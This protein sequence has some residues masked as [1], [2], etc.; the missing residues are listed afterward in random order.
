MGVGMS[1]A[2]GFGSPRMDATT[3]LGALIGAA[4]THLWRGVMLRHGL[5]GLPFGRL[6]PRLVAGVVTTAVAAELL[7]WAAGLFVTRAYTMAGSTPGVMFATAANWLFTVLSWTAIYVGAQWF[8]RWRDSEIQ[9]LRLE[10]LARDAQ[11]DALHAQIQ[12]HFLF[13]AM[14]VLRALI[15]EDPAR[16]RDLVTE[17][18]ELMRYALQAGRRER[19]TLAEE[20]SVVESYLRV[21]SARFEERLAWRIEADDGVRR[22]RLPPMLL[23]LLVENAVKHGIAACE[24]GGE[25]VVTARREGDRV[26]LRVTN[27]GRMGTHGDTRIGLS[28]A[29]ERLRLLY[30]D[31]AG[32]TLGEHD[33]HVVAEVILPAEEAT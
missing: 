6:L 17:L 10:V 5:L 7:V 16:A 15:P 2:F 23:Q 25:V 14:N 31:R 32:L 22:T 4:C 20:L 12:P 26:R 33:G 11:L 9:R 1:R 21:E 29:R 28:N 18:S 8:A 3:L 27:P 30:G 19:V 13:N 24:R